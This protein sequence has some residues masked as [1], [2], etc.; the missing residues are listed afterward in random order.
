MKIVVLTHTF[1]LDNLDP[2][3]AF[4]KEFCDGLA[5]NGHEV[6][7]VTPFDSRLNRKSDPF[8][9]I[10]YKYIWSDKL[11]L[12]GYSRTMEADVTLRKRAYLLVP[13]M[14]VFGTIRLIQIIK[15]E[16]IDIIN[17]H[18]IVPN[19][20]MA[21][22]ASVFT[23][24]PYTVTIPGTDAY[25]ATKYKLIG[26]VVRLITKRSL[27]ITANSS[28][29]LQRII[30]LGASPRIK[31]VISYPVDTTKFKPKYENL[32]FIRKRHSLKKEDLILLAVGR[33]VYKKGYDYLIKAVDK[34]KNTRVKLLIAGEGDL[35]DKWQGLTEDLGLAKRI[36]FIGNIKR[37]QIVDYY[38]LADIMV[39]PSIIDKEGNVD[40][41][42]VASFESMA[43]GKPQIVTDVLG[44]AEEMK[45]GVNGFI[46]PQR[47]V[48][49]LM[50]ALGQLIK[51]RTLREKMG[52]ANGELIRREINTKSIGKKY[53]NLFRQAL[54][55]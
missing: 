34:L 32:D 27:A 6:F 22:I 51:S 13:F 52:I 16:K 9:I 15:K 2:T 26:L 46:V 19:G 55:I 11:H 21:M 47:N 31:V 50:K 28:I 23:K 12:L 3:A 41:G 38:N 8:K 42:P 49:A 33:L 29:N 44:V 48:E 24:V 17:A 30:K 37:D 1:P 10:T 54:S 20:L 7:V 43:C 14:I 40:G 4:M 39:A 18:W 53:T 36:L 5:E 35:K 25:L 45:N